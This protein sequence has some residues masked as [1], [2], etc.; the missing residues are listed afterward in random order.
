MLLTR[1]LFLY[2]TRTY[3]VSLISVLLPLTTL[4]ACFSIFDVMSRLKGV[5]VP[6]YEILVLGILKIPFILNEILPMI[7]LITALYFIHTLSKRNEIIVLSTSGISIWKFLQPLL[8]TSFVIGVIFIA[9][10]QPLGALCLEIQAS[11][12]R[13]YAISKKINMI[14]VI[15]SGLYIFESL[16]SGNRI[17]T[18]KL[19]LRDEQAIQN[20]TILNL[21]FNNRPL[22]RIESDYAYFLSSGIQL[23]KNAFIVDKE[24]VRKNIGD[25]VLRSNISFSTIIKTFDSPENV[26]FWR[27]GGLATELEKAGIRADKF[28]NYYYKLLFRPIYCTAITLM[29]CCFLT[30]NPRGMSQWRTLGYGTA[31]GFI[32]HSAKEIGSI[33]MFAHGV[34]SFFAILMPIVII[35]LGSTLILVRLFAVNR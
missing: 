26:S 22:D 28:V 6:V 29:S 20:V 12:E 8:I 16:E 3:I 10:I 13:K 2:L 30:I 11:I 7:F 27:L 9:L 32:A 15:D 24:G 14:S 1:T 33:V 31:L 18:S 35:T 5:I 21:D 19:I 25:I 34:S 17:I 23:S 4:V